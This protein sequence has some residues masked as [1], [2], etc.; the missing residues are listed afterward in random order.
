MTFALRPAILSSSPTVL[1]SMRCGDEPV[2]PGAPPIS[3][4]SGSETL[5]TDWPLSRSNHSLATMPLEDGVAP[6]RKVECPT[7]VTVGKWMWCASV[8]TAPCSSNRARPEL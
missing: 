5:V 3:F 4:V 2:V 1:T 8:N 7:A 6:L